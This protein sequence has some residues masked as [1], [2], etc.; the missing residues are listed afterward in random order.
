MKYTDEHIA[1]LRANVKG[2]SYKEL[3]E[4]FNATFGTN[5][6]TGALGSALKRYGLLNGRDARF[7]KGKAPHNKGKPMPPEVKEKLKHTLFKKG[8]IAHNTRPV[9]SERVSKDGYIEV[10]FRDNKGLPPGGKGAWELKHRLVWMKHHGE[11]P[12]EHAV[13]FLDGNKRNFNIENLALISRGVHGI[14]NREG[15]R[16]DDAELSKTAV[17]IGELKIKINDKR[18]KKKD[19]EC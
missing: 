1:W 7:A 11:I 12:K 10:K 6:L 8:N 4:R 19:K 14:L 16:F 2:V 9:G 18:K 5:L 15:L 17:K 13:I 3:T